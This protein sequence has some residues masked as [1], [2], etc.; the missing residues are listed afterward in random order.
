MLINRPL[1]HVQAL[2]CMR[3]S[4]CLAWPFYL[5]LCQALATVK[6]REKGTRKLMWGT[7]KHQKDPKSHGS[8]FMS[9]FSS[10]L[11]SCA[12]RLQAVVCLESPH[13]AH[14]ADSESVWAWRTHSNLWGNKWEK[15]HFN[16]FRTDFIPNF[17]IF[18]T[19]FMKNLV[20]LSSH[21]CSYPTFFLWRD[22]PGME[23]PRGVGGESGGQNDTEDCMSL[24]TKN[25]KRFNMSGEQH[26]NNRPG[27]LKAMFFFSP[28]PVFFC[29]LSTR[30]CRNQCTFLAEADLKHQNELSLC[31]KKTQPA[32]MSTSS[33][34]P[35]LNSSISTTGPF[36]LLFLQVR[37]RWRT[38]LQLTALWHSLGYKPVSGIKPLQFF[39]LR[40]Y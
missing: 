23:S 5:Q 40:S 8:R 31:H 36:A 7:L 2:S 30:S 34:D 9:C 6:G 26:M 16:I 39:F 24:W 33:V 25:K 22:D 3:S 17:S 38:K 29:Y 21:P 12:L 15:P 27:K 11:A 37:S 4:A 14:K 20:Y 19:Y 35:T 1:G 28:G 18:R 10:F 13:H 32:D